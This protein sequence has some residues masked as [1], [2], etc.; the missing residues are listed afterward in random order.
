LYKK[1]ENTKKKGDKYLYTFKRKKSY[2]FELFGTFLMKISVLC[3]QEYFI[4]D[5]QIYCDGKKNR[6][7]I[8]AKWFRKSLLVINR[9][10]PF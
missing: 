1:K 7:E 3:Q 5:I 8:F 9:P 2:S 4:T 10:F 6:K